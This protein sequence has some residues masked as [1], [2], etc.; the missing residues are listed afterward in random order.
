VRVEH[1][2]QRE[3]FPGKVHGAVLATLAD[4]TAYFAFC[5]ASGS[6]VAVTK[7]MTVEY[8]RPMK[9]GQFISAK[10]A[11]KEATGGDV[12]V[13][14]SNESGQLCVRATVVYVVPKEQRMPG[15]DLSRI[16]LF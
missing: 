14:L 11:C 4:E 2:A 9:A 5:K 16:K 8:L 1:L 7:T 15:V 3:G 13:E 12:I 10:A 6:V